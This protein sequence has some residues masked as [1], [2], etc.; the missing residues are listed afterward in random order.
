MDKVGFFMPD[1]HVGNLI[2]SYLRENN[3]S[4]GYLAKLLNMPTSNLSRLLK[5]K[6]MNTR[7]LYN[8]SDVLDHNFFYAFM[9]PEDIYEDDD[10]PMG[11]PEIGWEIEKRLDELGMNQTEFATKL[12][13]TQSDDSRILKRDD[14]DT[15]KLVRISRVLEYNFFNYYYK[16]YNVVDFNTGVPVPFLKRYEELVIENERVKGK[17]L[18]IERERESLLEEIEK[19]KKQLCK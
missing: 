5:R 4:Q 10:R 6:S 15:D 12:N 9:N 8:I 14:I 19:L 3:I 11:L 16:D 17:L 18:E 7:K 2:L 13:T 1:V